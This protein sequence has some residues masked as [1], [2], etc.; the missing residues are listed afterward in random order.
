[1]TGF[2]LGKSSGNPYPSSFSL[3]GHFLLRGHYEGK[4][5]KKNPPKLSKM[6]M[7]QSHEK[8]CSSINKAQHP[9]DA[10]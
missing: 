2:D 7:S 1:V 6:S 10:I 8:V 3:I 4:A 5:L 9:K